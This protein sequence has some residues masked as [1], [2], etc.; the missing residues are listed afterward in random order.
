M[1]S[2]GH[3]H[4][5]L[6]MGSQAE[7]K[8]RDNNHEK[9]KENGAAVLE[10]LTD[11]P[12][13]TKMAVSVHKKEEEEGIKQP[14][15]WKTMPYIIGNEAC[16]KLA[17]IG[18]SSNIEVYLTSKFNKPN[19]EASFVINLWTGTSNIAPL[20]GAFLSDS[21]IGRYWT[22]ALG[23]IASLIGMILLSLTAIFP[24]LRPPPCDTGKAPCV[25]ASLGQN[26]L[27]YS[28]FAMMTI[29][30]GG[31]GPCSIAFGADQFDYTSEKGKR[32]IQSFF[33][34]FAQ[35]IVCAIKKRHLRLPSE[36]AW[37]ENFYDPPM[38]GSLK[39]RMAL[40]HQFMYAI[41]NPIPFVFFLNLEKESLVSGL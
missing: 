19:V 9:S 1:A 10:G 38:K 36:Q 5:Q 41:S 32:S 6:E 21:Y 30:A 37:A 18:L 13:P 35:V 25:G 2:H 3:K 23:C 16:E 29:G 28:S 15:G 4:L 40:T 20:L 24:S 12:D 11:Q 8:S 14:G 39:S 17:T 34:S 31:I 7:L 27:L 33:N 22:I 26:V